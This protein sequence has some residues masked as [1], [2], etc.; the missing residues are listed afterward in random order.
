[1]T[2]RAK[3]R[4]L[5]VVRNVVQEKP[6]SHVRCQA[7]HPPRVACSCGTFGMSRNT[8]PVHGWDAVDAKI[9][10][11]ERAL[12]IMG[13]SAN[14][15]GDPL[16]VGQVMYGHFTPFELAREALDGVVAPAGEEVCGRD[17]HGAGGD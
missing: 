3:Q 13:E 17:V 8:C 9:E 4:F 12:Q 1:M 7:G 5:C 14:W 11:Y 6:C 15:L 2:Q 16:E 10:R